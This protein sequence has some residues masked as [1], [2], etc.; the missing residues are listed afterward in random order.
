M[1]WMPCTPPLA[2]ATNLPYIQALVKESLRWRPA[3]PLGIPHATTEDDCY[4]GMFI[5]KGTICLVN[6]TMTRR[7]MAPM[8]QASIRRGSWTSMVSLLRVRRRHTMTD[9]VH[10]A[11]GGGLVLGSTRPM[12]RCSSIWPRYSGLFDWKPRMTKTG[13]RYLPIRTRLSIQEWFCESRSLFMS[14]FAL[15]R[16]V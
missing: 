14:S 9:T 6:I 16:R 3:L 11:L 8:L 1:N 12:T 4:E 5:P 13:R 2:D 10:M 7:R 15:G